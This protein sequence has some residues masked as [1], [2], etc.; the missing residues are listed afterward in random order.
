M[1]KLR[2]RIWIAII[3]G[4][5]G[6]FAINFIVTASTIID[7]QFAD[8]S[9]T[10]Q[11]LPGN[12][13]AIYKSRSGTVR[14]DAVGSVE[15]DL[16]GT[17]SADAYYAYFTP[18]GSP[19]NLSVGDSITF[20]GT[21]TLTGFVGTGQDV[22]FGLF[23][24]NGSRQ[25]ADL[26]NGNSAA[27]FGDDVGYAAQFVASPSG[28]SNPFVLY[29]RD[30]A[31]PAITNI[32][33]TFGAGSGFTAVTPGT[34]ATVRQALTNG[35]P[36]TFTYTVTRLSATQTQLTISVTGGA[37]TNLNFTATE[38]SAT[39]YTAFDWFDFRIPNNTFATKVKFTRIK[40]D[41][42]PA[43]PVI[44]TPPTPASQTVAAGSNAQYSVGAS[45][46]ELS[47]Q[48]FK[49]D[50][51]ITGNATA[52]T[53]N[54]QLNNVLPADG[55][56][57]KVTVTNPG[58]SSTSVPVT[59]IV[60]S[61]PVDPPPVIN[62]QPLDT[63]AVVGTPAS[64]SVT[65]TGLNLQYQWFKNDNL[66]GGE[67]GPTLSFAAV[68]PS[69]DA[70]YKVNVFNGG[71]TVPSDPAHLT[72]ASA[73][74]ATAF[75]PTNSSSGRCTDTP[76]AITF[77]Q[78]P[79]PGTT[80]H[81]RIFRSDGM[82]IEDIDMSN[83]TPT[84]VIGGNGTPY[85]YFPIIVTGSTA[86]IYPKQ[87]LALNQTYY[88]TI[89]PGVIL[90]P[91]NLPFAGFSDQNTWRFTTKTSAPAASVSLLSVAAD[92]T[93]DFCTL[94]GAI[95]QVPAGNTTRRIITVKS[96]TYTEIIYITSTKPFITVRGA[97]RDTSIVQYA[98]NNNLNGVPT[99]NNRTSFGVDAADFVLETIT[100]HNTTP[101]GG[102]QAEALRLNGL[103]ATV[104]SANLISFQDTL[105]TQKSAFITNSYIEGDVDFMWGN[106]ATYFKDTELKAMRN[107]GYY[108]QIRNNST[109]PGNTYVNCRLTKGPGITNGNYLGRIDPDDF[110]FSQ[111]TWIDTKMD[112]HMNPV[113]WLFNTPGL[114][115]TPANYPNI[116]YCEYNSTALDGVTPIDV[117]LRHPISCQLD[118]TQADFWRIPA[119]TLGGWV[120]DETLT[121][122]VALSNLSYTYDGT[123]KSATVTTDPT[124]ISVDVTYNGSA[125]LPVNAG[126]YPVVAT[127]T[128][129][130]YHGSASGTLVIS[131]ASVTVTLS[132]L[133]Q[134]YD[135]T[136]K[137]ATVM[138]NPPGVSTAVTYNGSATVPSAIGNYTVVA[139]VNDPNYS[140]SATGNLNIRST[141]KAFP[142]AEGTGAYTVGG[143]GG[144]VYHVTNLGDT[145]AG[146][147]RNG[148]QSATG[149]R[150][151]VFDIGGTI[152]LDSRLDINKPF[153]T[154][155]GQT[156]PGDGITVAG[157]TTVV[158]DTQHV[159]IRY[160]RFRAGDI[161]CA[162]GMEG[163]A[164]WV[165]N[166]KD[167][168]IDHVSAS[169]SIDES[170]SV[171]DSDRV[172]VQ[173]S[174]ITESLNFSCHPEGRH[175][176]GSL[177]RYGDGKLSFH[178]NL[179]AH[180]F[181]RNPR[182]GD[183]ITLDFV[184]NV[185]YDWGTDASY[186]GAVDEGITKVNYVGNYLVAGP[187]TPVNKRARA[188]NGG[189]VNTWIYQTGNLIDSNVNG[190]KDGVDTGWTMFVNLYTQQAS[191]M[192]RGEGKTSEE[193]APEALPD[194]AVDGSQTA[195]N[196]V[197]T[198]A[199][200]SPHR[201]AVDTRILAELQ[202]E[203]GGHINSQN[204]V[205]GFPLINSGP[206]PPDADGD[207]M[208]DVWEIQHA[209]NPADPNDGSATAP[210]GYTNLE[211][212][213][214]RNL[215]IPSAAGVSVSGRVTTADGRGLSNVRVTMTDTQGVA[216]TTITSAFGYYRFD[217]AEAGASYVISVLSKGH[218]F[219]I[220]SQVVTANDNISNVD[221]VA[222]GVGR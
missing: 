142:E 135:G 163:D 35:T 65:A 11:N 179:Y 149:P 31:V 118:S 147:L 94:Q 72:V 20:A 136:P 84:R 51:P 90:D 173:W 28:S 82:L 79:H 155:A 210:N 92:N 102:S 207:G 71:G 184:N 97:D 137:A 177:I 113:G 105:L 63:T 221:F 150:T 175:G 159:V 213:L 152:Y 157:W 206:L 21:F 44:N 19:V 205:G 25:T 6:I 131:Q 124:G 170:L 180:H 95:D 36:Y 85:R 83:A 59:L 96:G 201:D 2:T 7:D 121:A 161:R 193:A 141:L 1:K 111:V 4:L 219:G 151:I 38:T 69:D 164:L 77:N 14:T 54:L 30:V 56:A 130:G 8:G 91:L 101:Q 128:Q 60:S 192:A 42:I 112:T 127:V 110:P 218:T 55:G 33:N 211:N 66:M 215:L 78:V 119:N 132:D 52:T 49:D 41:Y 98:N 18:S 133:T 195:Y 116:K 13:L 134:N 154:L 186:S 75:S 191:P 93:G 185:I 68:Q 189:S 108:T 209:L 167:V 24:S 216:R 176:F 64:L 53:A 171:T 104:N 122:A 117:S 123:A 80:G 73:I 61:G 88:I 47:Y 46:V 190:V 126:S 48:W 139:T 22:R 16:T 203:N 89:D 187:N 197:V 99:G 138:T 146:S 172:T 86:T 103:R 153:L 43:A 100:L 156:A 109:T 23:N 169:W 114:P 183:N 140:G 208:P 194:I 222:D 67:N 81:A 106:G 15:Y 160:M 217:D 12:S 166:S 178:H 115:E 214:N 107:A 9:S 74:G 199:G 182:V 143:R 76:L 10:N 198:G 200:N 37:L 188:F 29:R 3:L 62:Q 174:F 27:A 220:A 165:D 87:Q 144:D 40:V 212:Y 50:N 158:R 145:G 202:N 26:A 5:A 17:T 181:N 32:F 70:I 204:D 39:P 120:P 57:Y 34:G 129:P 168:I 58:G 125:T 45:G 148:I 162:N 196:R